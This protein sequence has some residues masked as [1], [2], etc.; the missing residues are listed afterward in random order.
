MQSELL[1]I[2]EYWETDFGNNERVINEGAKLKGMVTE[3]VKLIFFLF[4]SSRDNRVNWTE[5]SYI[6]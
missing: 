1:Q 6:F 4:F 2:G 3:N 5:N